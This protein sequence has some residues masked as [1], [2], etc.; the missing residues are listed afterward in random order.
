[1]NIL[2][3]SDSDDKFHVLGEELLFVNRDYKYNKWESVNIIISSP[4]YDYAALVF[5]YS[6][7][8]LLSYIKFII[9]SPSELNWLKADSLI[10]YL[11]GKRFPSIT[12]FIQFTYNSTFSTRIKS[13]VR[14]G[15][16]S[17][18]DR[19]IICCP[20]KKSLEIAIWSDAHSFIR[21]N[22]HSFYIWGYKRALIEN[23]ERFIN[24]DMKFVVLETQPEEFRNNISIAGVSQKEYPNLPNKFEYGM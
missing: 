9:A 19:E 18:R 5:V 2:N 17:Y 13:S 11:S 7:I 24:V 4:L 1:M 23:I 14:N 16:S 8:A 22:N 6:N 15:K 10:I 21:K 12:Y 20:P 3:R